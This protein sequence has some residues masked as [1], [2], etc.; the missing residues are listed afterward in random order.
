LS[1]YQYSLISTSA[2]KF[3]S[4]NGSGV[5]SAARGIFSHMTW[6]DGN[7]YFDQGGCCNADTRTYVAEINNLNAWDIIALRSNAVNERSIWEN[8][9]NL[10]SNTTAPAAINL[11][12]RAVNLATSD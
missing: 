8:G 7:I 10:Q 9:S 6:S 12:G 2:L 11:D 1:S 3:Y 5:T 4:S